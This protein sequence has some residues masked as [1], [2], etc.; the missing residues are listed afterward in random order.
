MRIE[1]AAETNAYELASA[2]SQGLRTCSS[3][4]W[5]VLHPD[6]S[7]RSSECILSW[8]TGGSTRQ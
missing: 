2:S 8:C 4:S 7:C 3:Q 5:N 1:M 6:G